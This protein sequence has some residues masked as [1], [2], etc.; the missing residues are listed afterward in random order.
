[1]ELYN[2]EIYS[3]HIKAYIKYTGDELI[4]IILCLTHESQECFFI[5][6]GDYSC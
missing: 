3:N 5:Y 6:T 1:M 2:I 4:Y